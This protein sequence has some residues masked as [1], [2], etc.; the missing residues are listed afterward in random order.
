MGYTFFSIGTVIGFTFIEMD[1]LRTRKMVTDTVSTNETFIPHS[2]VDLL[3][4]IGLILLTLFLGGRFLSGILCS[5]VT[6]SG[7][8]CCLSSNCRP[9]GR[10]SGKQ[11]H[12]FNT[13]SPIL[14][15]VLI[16]ESLG[17][18]I[19]HLHPD[20]DPA[21]DADRILPIR[22]SSDPLDAAMDRSLAHGSLVIGLPQLLFPPGHPC[23]RSLS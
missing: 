14:F 6:S 2:W 17:D 20:I 11:G 16:Y 18:L 15:I 5:F 10:G 7:S 4:L 22:S 21:A 12:Y 9:I 8:V 1:R 23:C 19:H 3:F 13:F